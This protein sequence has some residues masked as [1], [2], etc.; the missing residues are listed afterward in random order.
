MR[1]LS[2][3]RYGLYHSFF[4]FRLRLDRDGWA[5]LSPLSSLCIFLFADVV[6]DCAPGALSFPAT[7]ASASLMSERLPN[8]RIKHETK[9]PFVKSSPGEHRMTASVSVSDKIPGFPRRDHAGRTAERGASLN[10][11]AVASVLRNAADTTCSFS[12]G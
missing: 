2:L 3:P 9:N 8:E 1:P 12:S 6:T 4:R 5:V 11:P 7:A 10:P